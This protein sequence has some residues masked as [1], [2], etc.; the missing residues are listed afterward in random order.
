MCRSVLSD[1][2]H[3]WPTCLKSPSAFGNAFAEDPKLA[4]KIALWARDIRGGAGER[5]TFRHVL[6][7]L[8]TYHNPVLDKILHLVP[9]V[10]RWDDLFVFTSPRVK[11]MSQNSF[12]MLLPERKMVLR[13]NGALGRVQLQSS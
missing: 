3:S 6:R 9:V 8:E 13:L 12:G 2:R 10:G 7:Y 4:T 5:E 1:C 11:R